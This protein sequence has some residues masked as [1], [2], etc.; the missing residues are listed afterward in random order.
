VH[1]KTHE[2]K[3]EC[4][5]LADLTPERQLKGVKLPLPQALLEL[6]VSRNQP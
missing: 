5:K 1:H 6:L 2:K 4:I 3:G